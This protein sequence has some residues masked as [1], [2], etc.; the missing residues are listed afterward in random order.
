MLYVA[1]LFKMERNKI[2]INIVIKQNKQKNTPAF[3]TYGNY[4]FS[5]NFKFVDKINFRWQST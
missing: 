1:L 3:F 5:V 4:V 2:I